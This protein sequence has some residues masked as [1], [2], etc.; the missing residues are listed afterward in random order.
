MFSSLLRPRTRRVYPDH[1]PFPN[2]TEETSCRDPD[3]GQDT[4]QEWDPARAEDADES[5]EDTNPG[6][7]QETAPLL[8][9]FS[10]SHLG[11]VGPPMQMD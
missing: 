1:S 9:M 7:D 2:Y 8:P 11:M 6:E 3:H 10:A 5:E 4:Y